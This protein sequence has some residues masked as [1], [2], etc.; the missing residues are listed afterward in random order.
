MRIIRYPRGKTVK[1]ITKTLE[2]EKRKKSEGLWL[3]LKNNKPVGLLEGSPG[4]GI[5]ACL[6]KNP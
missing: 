3:L 1:E 5:K 2:L 4:W 6:T